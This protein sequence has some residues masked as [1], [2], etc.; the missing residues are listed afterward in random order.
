MPHDP[1][2]LRDILAAAGPP[3]TPLDFRAMFGGILAYVD[4]RPLASLSDVGLA[5]KLTG[6]EHAAFVAAGAVPLRYEPDAPPS[7]TYLVVPDDLLGD[8]GALGAWITRAIANVRAAP[9]KA[10]RAR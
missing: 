10:K 6:N 1:K 5:L 3:D 4:G 9:A 2:A 8:V 7:K